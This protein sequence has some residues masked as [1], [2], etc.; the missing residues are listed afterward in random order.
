MT[1]LQKEFDA[2][3]TK[4]VDFTPLPAGRY[5]AHIVKTE[6]KATK[7]GNGKYLALTL[8][9]TEGEHKGRKLWD[10]LNLENPSTQAVEIA[11][12]TLAKICN[13]VGKIKIKDGDELLFAE[14]DVVLAT[15]HS[16]GFSPKN[17]VKDYL[18]VGAVAGTTQ[19][20]E[21]SDLPI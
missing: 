16:L 3:T 21:N 10:N 19:G 15:E 18:K 17:V 7:T 1:Q 4:I 6:M 5:T 2:S 9:I 20:M 14:L 11:E 8:E 13:S 12:S